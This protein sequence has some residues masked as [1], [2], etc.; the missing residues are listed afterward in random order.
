M[1]SSNRRLRA[2]WIAV[3]A[4]AIV[5]TGCGPAADGMHFLWALDEGSERVLSMEG[6]SATVQPT[7]VRIRDE[8]GSVIVTSSTRVIDP[9]AY[10]GLCGHS[11]IK[12]PIWWSRTIPEPVAEALRHHDYQT[13]TFEGQ[14]AGEWRQLS[15]EDTGCRGHGQG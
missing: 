11:P 8:R 7:A 14:I 2:F 3:L 6:G 5:S 13:F 12:A 9:A 10:K 15:L 4:V 1:S